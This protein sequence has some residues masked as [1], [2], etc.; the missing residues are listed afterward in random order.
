M[1][2]IVVDSI[3]LKVG[4]GIMKIPVNKLKQGVNSLQIIRNS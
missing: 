1:N 3:I 4:H 2:G